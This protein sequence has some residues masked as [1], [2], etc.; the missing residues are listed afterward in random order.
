MRSRLLLRSGGWLVLL[1]LLTHLFVAHHD[2]MAD[3]VLC[4]DPDGHM[5]VESIFDHPHTFF[6]PSGEAETKI[7]SAG[8]A[9]EHVDLSWGHPASYTHDVPAPPGSMQREVNF[10]PWHSQLRVALPV[11]RPWGQSP[12]HATPPP[13]QHALLASTC[14][15]I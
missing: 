4:V 3:L 15:L 12:P 9:C 5:T 10:L 8:D 6:L 2:G 1:A 14:L 7:T 11:H 13:S